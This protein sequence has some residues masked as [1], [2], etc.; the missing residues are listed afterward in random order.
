MN[1]QPK[2]IIKCL[3]YNHASYLRD[4][5]E[6]FVRQKTNFPF[7][8]IVHDDCSTD[9]SA[10]II[11]KYAER[12]PHIIEPIYETENQYSKPGHKITHIMDA[13]SLGRSP[14][15]AICE[16]DDYWID[17]LKLQ[18]QIDYMDAHPD[19]TL[20][21]TN[22]LISTHNKLQTL[23]EIGWPHPHKTGKL[24]IKDLILAGGSYTATCTMVYRSG[25]DADMPYDAKFCSVWDYPLQIF[26][27]L[28]GYVY[29]FE[30]V[31]AV[32][33]FCHPGSWTA[34]QAKKNKTEDKPF[35]TSHTYRM[36]RMLAA[37]DK[38]SREAHHSH[39]VNMQSVFIIHTLLR[40]P[41][42]RTQILNT[43]GWVLHYH[44]IAPHVKSGNKSFT[45]R[46]TFLLKFLLVRPYYPLPHSAKAVLPSCHPALVLYRIYLALQR[47]FRRLL[48]RR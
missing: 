5:L 21:C 38:Y 45:Q 19:C 27:G 28:K 36:Y 46:I 41:T 24:A 15:L 35:N 14:Y 29:Y 44:H 18:K 23:D 30:D 40:F 20:T 17:P 12:Y 11:R 7:K 48:I 8:A 32:Y 16:G 37:M 1:N 47:N 25:L 39:F 22:H 33:R 31:C 42:Q 2:V 13:A 9:G 6:G 43:L 10:A 4:C 26:A 34:A 3:V